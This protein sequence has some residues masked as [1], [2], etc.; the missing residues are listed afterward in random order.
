MI[1]HKIGETAGRIWRTLEQQGQLRLPALKK[2]VPVPE[3]MLYLALGWLAREDRVEIEP[4]GR[5]Y[6]VGLK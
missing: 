1:I 5:S 2:Q 6:R 3:S 4:D